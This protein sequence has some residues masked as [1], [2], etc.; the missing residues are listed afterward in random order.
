MDRLV[1]MLD[2]EAVDLGIPASALIER[3]AHLHRWLAVDLLHQRAGWRARPRGAARSGSER[4]YQNRP[5]DGRRA[6]RADRHRNDRGCHLR[7]DQRRQPRLAH[8]TNT[9]TSR[10]RSRAVCHLRGDRAH[11]NSAADGPADAGPPSGSGRSVPDAGGYMC[12]RSVDPS[13]A[14]SN[15]EPPTCTTL[16]D[17]PAWSEGT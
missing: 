16:R 8:N 10:C 15:G 3:A 12:I 17:C 6:R 13:P 4:P 9:D 2:T 7:P 5:R 14:R 1:F 11:G